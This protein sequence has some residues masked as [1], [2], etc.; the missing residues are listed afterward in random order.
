MKVL[1]NMIDNLIVILDNPTKTVKLVIGA[2]ALTSILF[3]TI[4]LMVIFIKALSYS[5]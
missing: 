4:S 5:F 2:V 1:Q 3:T